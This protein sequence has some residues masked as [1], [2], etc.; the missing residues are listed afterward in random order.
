MENL[1]PCLDCGR[2]MLS[3][4][5]WRRIPSEE[6]ET[7]TA[8]RYSARGMCVA[9]HRR[10]D[11]FSGASGEPVPEDVVLEEWLWLANPW[12]PDNENVAALAPRLGMSREGLAKAVQRLR[13]RGELQP[14]RVVAA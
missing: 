13:K 14:P 1:N 9:C 2:H 8:A 10:A 12:I 4:Y 3:D 5:A 6:R 7:T 11:R